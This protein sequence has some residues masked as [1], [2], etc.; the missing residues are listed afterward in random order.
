VP[1]SSVPAWVRLALLR[2]LALAPT[3]RWP[4]LDALLTALAH[5]PSRARRRRLAWLGAGALMLGLGLG[6]GHLQAREAAAC[7]ASGDAVAETWSTTAR[8]SVRTALL[9]TGEPYAEDAWT[10]VAGRLDAWSDAWRVAQV[11][12]C[13]ERDELSGPRLVCLGDRL[14]HLRSLVGLL[15]AAD[16]K[17][18]AEAVR[19]AANLPSIAVC[20][21]P[22][23]L[24]ATLKPPEDEQ[25]RARVE[26]ERERLSQA[27]AQLHSGHYDEAHALASLASQAADALDY[28]PLRAEAR[29]HLGEILE[30]QGDYA[31]SAS[32]LESAYDLAAS[33]GHDQLA[34]R[35]TIALLRVAGKRLAQ[36]DAGLVWSRV[37]AVIV[38]RLGEDD[39]LLGADL[40]SDL[41]QVLD[42]RGDSVAAIERAREALAIREAKL[43][44]DHPD[45]AASLHNL[46]VASLNLGAL[47][48][49]GDYFERALTIRRAVLGEDHPDVAASYNW[50][51]N[52]LVARGQ[53]DAGIGFYRKAL[54]IRE[55]ALP[56]DHPDIASSL[57]NL[58]LALAEQRD[59]A[60]A[61]ELQRRALALR[62]RS[63]APDHPDIA[64]SWN[65]LGTVYT[66]LGRH[67][68]ARGHYQ[69]A[70]NRWERS[71]GPTHPALAFALLGIGKSHLEQG[72]AAAAL[73]PLERALALRSAG[74]VG[75]VYRAD[76]QFILA[77]SLW[78][79]RPSERPRARALAEAARRLFSDDAA[80]TPPELDRWLADHPA[81]SP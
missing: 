76:A 20:D 2:G 6:L 35:A 30:R 62:E 73:A 38:A 22:G 56:A 81:P 10:S 60:G 32:T 75:A 1:R 55:R 13:E 46:G 16:R 41:G 39:G 14:R 69:E 74:E 43:G 8:E 5:D 21:D 61:L 54:A 29:Q 33:T 59:F 12:A 9:A 77:R 23:W 31:A 18:A 48:A 28:A 72:D 50:L 66:A 47:E 45:V 17:I 64:A 52:T 51:G 44:H 70:L 34:A 78:D 53:I 15:S 58:G 36:H 24:A 49:A 79:A 80:D 68:E 57:S 67:A 63:L 27:A 71:L 42:A 65:N 26:D 40:R 19:L 25:V 37:A 3:A 7:V 11:R 4:T